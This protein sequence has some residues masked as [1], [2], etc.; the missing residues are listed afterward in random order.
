MSS[1][2]AGEATVSIVPDLSGFQDRLRADLKTVTVD[3][4]VRIVPDL[5]DFQ[6]RLKAALAAAGAGAGRQGGAAGSSYGDEFT[7][8]VKTR[9]EAALRSLPEVQIG[10]ATNEAEQKLRDLNARL[11]ALRD[12]RI[13]VDIDARVALAEVKRIK[14]ELDTLSRKSPDIQVRVDAGRALAELAAVQ[15]EVNKL[16]GKHADVKVDSEKATSGIS[17]LVVAIA[18]IGPALIPIGA[19]AIAGLGGI[20]T[21]AVA[22]GAALGVLYLGLSGVIGAVGDVSAA[23]KSA[24]ADAKASAAAQEAAAAAVTNAQ[25]SLANAIRNADNSAISSAQAVA[26]A[27][28]GVEDAERAA[29]A[30]VANALSGQETAERAL[31]QAVQTAQQAEESLTAARKTAEQQIQDLSLSVQNGALAQ[32]QANLTVE[33]SKANLDKVLS[34]P[35]S[36]QLQRQQ[37]QLTYDQA[38]QQVTDIGV[39]QG[40][41]TDQKAAADRA[42]VEGSATVISAQRGVSTAVQGVSTAQ[43]ALGKAS[44]AV[45]EAQRSGTE[46]VEKAQQSLTDAVRAQGQ[47]AAASQATIASAQ[48]ALV[49]A[50]D[51]AADAAT[52]TSAAA[53]KAAASLKLLTPAGQEFVNF[54]VSSLNPV[55]SG[56]KDTAQA[57]LL[58]GLE[59]GIKGLL[60]VMPV[61]N[62]AVGKLARTMGDLFRAAGQAL[63]SPFYRE[64][65]GYLGDTGSKTIDQFGR[66]LGNTISGFA[67]LLLAFAPLADGIG[68]GLVNLTERFA[69]FG[70]NTTGSSGFQGF[71]RY[72]T[73]VS[74]LV[75]K[76]FQ[77]LGGALG[78]LIQA[79]A[80][81]G[82]VA[83]QVIGGV[84]QLVTALGPTGLALALAGAGVAFVGFKLAAG[85]LTFTPALLA[86]AGLTAAFAKLYA[87]KGPDGADGGFK[88]FIDDRTQAFGKDLPEVL[89]LTGDGFSKLGSLFTGSFLKSSNTAGENLRALGGTLGKV[90]E[91]T[92]RARESTAVLAQEQKTLS[93]ATGKLDTATGK[94]ND[95]VQKSIS[96]FTIL[97]TGTLDSMTA[98]DSLAASYDALSQTFAANGTSLDA[99]SEKGRA[100]RKAINDVATALNEKATADFKAT[101]KTDGLTAAT[102]QA[103]TTVEANRQKLIENLIQTGLS[104][105]AAEDYTAKLLLTP[106]E[107]RTQVNTPGIDQAKT[108]V[109]GL[110]SAIDALK[111]KSITISANGIASFGATSAAAAFSATG[112]AVPRADGGLLTGPGTGTSDSILMAASTG[113]FVVKASETAKNLPLLYAVN[114]GRIP[115][116][117]AGG[118]VNRVVDVHGTSTV[119]AAASGLEGLV[120]AAF[121]KLLSA[122]AAATYAASG[123]VGVI[124][125]GEHLAIIN[126]ALSADRVPLPDWPRWQAG[127]NTLI[128]RESGWNPGIFNTTDINA[129][130]GTPSGG[131]AQVIGPT[132]AANRNPSLPNNLLDSVANVAASV[133]YIVSRYGDISNVQQANPN[134]P[135]LGYDTGG[136]LPPGYSSIYN[137]TGQNEVVL[138]PQQAEWVQQIIRGGDRGGGAVTYVGTSVGGDLIVSDAA[139]H[140]RAQ[141]SN[142]LRASYQHG[143]PQS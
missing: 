137:G 39:R 52:K 120:S 142:M 100:N 101:E 112:A 77:D 103:T 79:L 27:R 56:L 50:Q 57:G 85:G 81:F 80:P 59:D 49:T 123:A 70:Q 140:E 94:L 76:T 82:V 65:I 35:A 96:K 119:G 7:R 67:G 15:A 43:D 18:T 22:G 97:R 86:I 60:P 72:V 55:L 102:N 87:D 88:K 89:N 135:P 5:V 68:K 73:E 105:Q 62:E 108:Q 104:R 71:L 41:L 20:A 115:A 128:E 114:E 113:E 29:S 3:H 36:S 131:L 14:E 16:D 13:G 47:Q 90:D 61:V 38:V 132:F 98:S 116:F 141:R 53:D 44:A 30:G 110:Q 117:A 48:R 122:P 78:T 34:N 118:L 37:A 93:D 126:A 4:T 91:S 84:S 64:F 63:S 121:T 58:P 11:V 8:V 40:R 124:P 9:I 106:A 69:A 33:T 75:V 46:R 92:T 127:M 74:P 25:S 107:I 133:N 45:V 54:I 28:R 143:L 125:V 1:Y 23:Q 10:V 139:E 66:I 6:A 99:N 26:N 136:L 51:A 129:I 32:R 111:D 2:S 19:A 12:A 138:N 83:L 17:G 21:L 109:Q 31:T 24:G 95:E 130:N 134:L 42:G